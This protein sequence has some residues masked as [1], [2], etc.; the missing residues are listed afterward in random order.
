LRCTHR[1]PVPDPHRRCRPQTRTHSRRH[2]R[3]SKV[4]RKWHA[5]A[6]AALATEASERDS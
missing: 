1:L 2:R 3:V 5:S 4:A 6:R